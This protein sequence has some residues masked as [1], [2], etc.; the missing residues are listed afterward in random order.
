MANGYNPYQ[1]AGTQTGFM[2]NLL[3]KQQS[4]LGSN[5]AIGQH[6]VDM[7]TAFE[8]EQIRKQREFQELMEKKRDKNPIEKALPLLQIAFPGMA[9]IMGALGAGIGTKKDIDFEKRKLDNMKGIGVGSTSKYGNTFLGSKSRG[10]ESRAQ[11]TIDS[12]LKDVKGIGTGGILT[13]AIGGALKGEALSKFGESLAPEATISADESLLKGIEDLD[14]NLDDITS[15]EDIDNLSDE[16]FSKLHKLTGE[17]E[18]EE[19]FELITG[20]GGLQS[21]KS[22]GLGEKVKDTNFL[23]N[24]IGKISG[25]KLDEALTGSDAQGYG[26]LSY[27][28]SS[29]F[30]Q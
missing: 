1:I 3:Q 15:L 9:P 10:L 21:L 13:S 6:K 12:L 29:I 2:E 14:F 5:L 11:E 8:K 26:N 30:G 17:G 4:E 19:L 23:E 16:Q 7:T 18:T 28:L 27:L 24:I 25:T 22:S 20:E